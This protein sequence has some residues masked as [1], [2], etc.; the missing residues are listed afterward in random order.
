MEYNEPVMSLD[1][2]NRPKVLKNLDVMNLKFIRLLLMEPGTWPDQPDKGVGLVSRFRYIRETDLTE[3]TT[4][5]E[6]QIYEYIPDIAG[7]TATLELKKGVLHISVTADETLYEYTYDGKSI[8]NIT[9]ED[10]MQ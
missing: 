9:M 1:Q 10:V 3:I 8:K 5:Y 2:Y 7:V 6:K 4:D